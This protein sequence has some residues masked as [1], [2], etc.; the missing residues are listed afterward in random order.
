MKRVLAVLLL[1]A[2]VAAAAPFKP[3][4][5]SAGARWLFHADLERLRQGEIG[6]ALIAQMEQ[7]AEAKAG[8]DVLRTLFAF[9]PATDLQ[10]LTAYGS[11][12]RSQED[13]ALLMGVKLKEGAAAFTEKLRV[14]SGQPAIEHGPC[15]IVAFRNPNGGAAPAGGADAWMSMFG[16]DTLVMAK[17][18]D[19][20]K[21]ALDTLAGKAGHLPAGGTWYPPAGKQPMLFISAPDVKALAPAQDANANPA[22]A[23]VQNASA[24]RLT[25]DETAGVAHATLAVTAATPEAAAQMQMLFQGVLAMATLQQAPPAAAGAAPPALDPRQELLL[26]LLRAITVST[27][28]NTVQAALRYPAVDLVSALRAM[29]P[30]GAVPVPAPVP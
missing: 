15:K 9:D 13:M 11:N 4:Q 7:D 26:K 23:V 3:E 27:Q 8:L 24:V 12:P 21:A 16:G 29:S 17:T 22:A 1:A 19:G 5:V 6:K 25:V 30:G 2:T 28:G 10:G 18:V 14:A 20:V